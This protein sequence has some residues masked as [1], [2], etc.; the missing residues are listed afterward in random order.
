MDWVVIGS[1]PVRCQAI[2]WTNA[3]TGILQLDPQEQ[4]AMPVFFC[5]KL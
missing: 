3:D 2:I 1:D 4:L 5:I